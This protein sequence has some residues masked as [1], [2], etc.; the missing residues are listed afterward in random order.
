MN[1]YIEHLKLD[2]DPFAPSTA[3]RDFYCNGQRQQLLD[4]IIEFSLYS[5]AMIAV[6]GPLG[7]GKTTLATNF[8]NRF[9]DEAV[10]V[11][12]TATLFMHQNQFLES[13]QN[14]LPRKTTATEDVDS[15]IEHICHYAAELDLE[16][17]SLIMIIDDAHELGADVLQLITRLLEKCVD[18][19]IHVLLFGENQLDS[20]LMSTLSDDAQERL[21]VFA[22]EG[23]ASN[24]TMEYIRFKLATA[25]F[26]RDL[27]IADSVIGAIHNS[28]QGMPG[29]INTMIAEALNSALQINE[30]EITAPA[31]VARDSWLSTIQ[32]Q[33]WVV[34]ASL[35]L[36][37]TATLIFWDSSPSTNSGGTTTVAVSTSNSGST[38]IE[39]PVNLLSVADRSQQALLPEDNAQAVIIEQEQEPE[40]LGV[41][42]VDQSEA[43]ILEE[44]SQVDDS[45]AALESES[46]EALKLQPEQLELAVA[47]PSIE[48]NVLETTVIEEAIVLPQVS[49]FEQHL[50]Q[51]S[52][53]NYTVQLLASHSEVNIK[54]FIAKLDSDQVSGYFETRLKE[55][56]WFVAVIG[57]FSDREG[58]SSAIQDLPQSL[59]SSRPWVRL[60]AAIQD[61]IRQLQVAKLVTAK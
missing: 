57:N 17:R 54:D 55:K 24:E 59:R 27:P 26:A 46:S 12:V 28:S 20:L 10:C 3:S 32:P 13:L 29:A 51:A 16:A 5:N 31:D 60:I 38:R 8:C 40:L 56:P 50:L 7:A 48:E 34:A 43:V 15:V 42:E 49:E 22:L 44:L 45:S 1:K 23:Y 19:S 36:A 9:S 47:T 6:T 58:A 11:K 39:I 4:Q 30:S 2:F 14:V 37:L 35:V 21:A 18:S 53:Q 52:P 33:Y 41:N 61:D 25:G